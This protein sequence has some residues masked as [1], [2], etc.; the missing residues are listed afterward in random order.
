MRNGICL[1]FF[2]LSSLAASGGNENKYPVD[3]IPPKLKEAVNVVVRRKVWEYEI[4]SRS[5]AVHRVLEA[6]TILNAE[7]KRFAEEVVFYDK[8]SKINAFKGAVYDAS[9]KQIRKLKSA[10]IYDQ[11]AISGFS[12]YE[13]NRLKWCDLAQ[14]VYPYTV[15]FEYE[16]E[17]KYLFHIPTYLPISDEKVSLEYG[18][19]EVQ[20]P[21]SGDLEPRY[22]TQ[23]TSVEPKRGKKAGSRQTG[24]NLLVTWT[25]AS[26]EPI[27][28]EPFSPPAQ[29]LFPAVYVAPSNFEFEKY[30]GAMDNWNEFGH[31]IKTLNAG[32]DVLPEETKEK[33]KQLTAGLNTVQEKTKALYE[34]MQ[35]KTRYVSIQMGIGGFQPFEATVVDETGYGDCKALS[36]YMVAL[37]KQAGIPANY[38]L[39]RAGEDAAEINTDFASTQFNH[40]IAFVPMPQDTIW[41]ECTSQTNPFGYLGKFTFDRNAL[42]ITEAGAKVVRTKRYP[43]ELNTQNRTA[44]VFVRDNGD[45]SAKIS[46]I[47]RGLQYENGG[48]NFALESHA[49][50]QKKWVLRNTNIPSFEVNKFT[51][52]NNKEMIPSATLQLDLT[53]RKL[54]NVSGK[55]MF[56]TPNLMNR[57]NL[58]PEKLDGRKTEVF[59]SFGYVDNDTIRFHIPESL[60]PEFLPQPTKLKSRFGEYESTFLF[61]EGVVV[62][63]RSIKIQKGRF[64]AESYAEFSEFHRNVNKA[65]N[66]RL[67]FLTKT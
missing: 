6:Y 40:A 5:R 21:A 22:K 42:A 38:T 54:A 7:G 61:D 35:S 11:S 2:L 57:S 32:R 14:G 39:I 67:V 18:Q 41:L 27:K 36:N 15:E 63:T 12:L 52:I 26:L 55:R 34:Y 58:L 65:D 31:W 43:T 4:I 59:R 28:L 29:E 66:I 50:D 64:P 24:D 33:V 47:Y 9:G 44:D 62:Y 3:S 20:Y 49:E 19:Y 46:T 56:L 25:F 37:L 1:F 30:T 45:A 51:F 16:V 23:N 48:L 53:L 17:Y 8:L 60:Y 10:E 13:D